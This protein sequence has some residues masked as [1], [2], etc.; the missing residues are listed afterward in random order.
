MTD[1]RER[2]P[3]P[4][5]DTLLGLRGSIKPR[6]RPENL[7]RVRAVPAVVI[8]GKLADC[9]RSSGPKPEVIKSVGA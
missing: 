4:L 9:C 3:R 6:R 5:K 2:E 8:D 7:E 1:A